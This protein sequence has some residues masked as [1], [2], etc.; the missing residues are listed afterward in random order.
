MADRDDSGGPRDRGAGANWP[1][2]LP[3]IR[4]R[5][6]A[7]QEMSRVLDQLAPERAAHRMGVPVGEVERYRTPRGCILQGPDAAVSVSWFP[8]V[9]QGAAIGELQVVA[10]SGVVSRPGSS[11]RTEGAQVVEEMVLTPFESVPSAW[12]WRAED[13]TTYDTEAL[14]THCLAL[15]AHPRDSAGRGEGE[16]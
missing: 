2:E 16:Q 9:S 13:G 15:L 12:T 3:T 4:E 11:T 7:Q 10:W 14:V 6:A 8:D 1:P 5:N